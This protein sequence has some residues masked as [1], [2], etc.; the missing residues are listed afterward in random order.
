MDK[1]ERRLAMIFRGSGMADM[2]LALGAI[3][4]QAADAHHGP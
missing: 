2:Q 3:D 4:I 1:H